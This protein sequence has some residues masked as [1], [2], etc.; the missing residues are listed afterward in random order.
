[1]TV[2][3]R[4]L[5]HYRSQTER[6]IERATERMVQTPYGEFKLIAFHDKVADETHLALVKGNPIPSQETLVRVHEPLSIFDLIDHASNTHS[7]SVHKAMEAMQSAEAGVIVLLRRPESG[8]QLIERI[9]DVDEPVRTRQDLRDYGIGSQILRDLGVGKMRLL[10][11]PRKMPS[12]TGF[13]L[14][15]T[16]Y[17]EK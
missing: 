6:L 11:V 10:A 1:M 9:R 8:Q 3:W 17:V 12:M 15:V 16:G 13:D 5:I 7:W 2:A 4:A 14:E